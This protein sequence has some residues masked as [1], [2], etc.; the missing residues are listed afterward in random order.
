MPVNPGED[1]TQP[2]TDTRPDSHSESGRVGTPNGNDKNRAPGHGD[3][4]GAGNDL[5][6]EVFRRRMDRRLTA[7]KEQRNL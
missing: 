6:P 3:R 5:L 7:K 1:P 2:P 4:Y